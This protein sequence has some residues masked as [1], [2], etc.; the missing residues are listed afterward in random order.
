MS[1]LVLPYFD[2]A[3]TAY[4]DINHAIVIKLQRVEYTCNIYLVNLSRR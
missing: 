1:T 2:F 3:V 4:C